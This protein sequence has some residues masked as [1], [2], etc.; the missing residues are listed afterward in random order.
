MQIKWFEVTFLPKTEYDNIIRMGGYSHVKYG[1]DRNVCIGSGADWNV[2]TAIIG[3]HSKTALRREL[4]QVFGYV[5]EKW[6][7]HQIKEQKY[8]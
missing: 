7:Y 2:S 3:A 4:R 8:A 6:V 1:G 5:Y